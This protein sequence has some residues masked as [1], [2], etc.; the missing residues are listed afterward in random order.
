MDPREP[1]HLFTIRW[2]QPY[3]QDDLTGHLEKL[4][5]VLVEQLLDQQ[6]F[7]E[8]REALDRIMKL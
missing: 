8:A 2:T 1:K 4:R 3:P 5:D 7:A 6:D